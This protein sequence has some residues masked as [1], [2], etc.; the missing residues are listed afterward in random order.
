MVSV[1]RRVLGG[2]ACAIQLRDKVSSLATIRR[3]AADL[4]R[5]CSD[6][7]ALLVINDDPALARDCD[8]DGV[9][10]GQTDA[11]VPHCRSVLADHQFVGKSNATVPE[12]IAS[13]R[14]GA[15]Y[16]AV[17]SIFRTTTKLNTR[18]A[19]LETLREVASAAQLPVVAVGGIDFSNIA[20]VAEAGADAAC[21]ASAVTE[22]DDPERATS[23]LLREFLAA[24]A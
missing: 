3:T 2:G 10:V 15:D 23:R 7:D 16:V 5:L 1:A 20:A 19:G 21:V 24:R 12:A 18:P 11:S 17:G 6:A 4:R 22:A 14:E 13:A 9:H 8:A